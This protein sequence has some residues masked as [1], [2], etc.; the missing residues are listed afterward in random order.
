MTFESSKEVPPQGP[1]LYKNCKV[2]FI[3]QAANKQNININAT[4]GLHCVLK[5]R[6]FL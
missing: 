2:R 3:P 6:V 4:A 5:L 1:T